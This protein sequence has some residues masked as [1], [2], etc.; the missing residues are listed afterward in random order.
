ME[1]LMHELQITKVSFVLL[2][3]LVT[4]K[5]IVDVCQEGREVVRY[6]YQQQI[7]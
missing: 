4:S 7:L 3:P 5:T 6:A 1:M 2:C